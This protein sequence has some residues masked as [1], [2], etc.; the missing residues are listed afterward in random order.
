MPCGAAAMRSWLARYQ[1]RICL[2]FVF[3]AIVALHVF[4]LG[5]RFVADDA[6]FARILDRQPLGEFLAFRYMHWSGRV[7][8]EATLVLVINH[9]WVWRLINAAMLLLFCHS[10]GR[11]ALA[12]TGKSGAT[13]TSPAFAFLTMVSPDMLYP[14]PWWMMIGRASCRDRVCRSS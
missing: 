12:S 8:I 3:A 13:T 6:W 9:P 5:H 1:G 2:L 7:P 10:A 14:A 11:L 4:A